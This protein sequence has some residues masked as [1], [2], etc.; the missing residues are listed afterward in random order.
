MVFLEEA[1]LLDA[2]D[3]DLF[4]F[5]Q[6]AVFKRARKKS[7]IDFSVKFSPGPATTW[8]VTRDDFDNLLIKDVQSR[9]AH[10][11]FNAMVIDV[12]LDAPPGVTY[13]INEGIKIKAQTFPVGYI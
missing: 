11:K 6:G 8:Q 4:Q 2:I 9:G 12:K 3:P 13:Q 7:I 1:G 5:K 10:V